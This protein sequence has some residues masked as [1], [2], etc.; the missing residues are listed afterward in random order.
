MGN[1]FRERESC[2]FPQTTTSDTGETRE[3]HTI[4]RRAILKGALGIGAV[5]VA[6]AANGKTLDLQQWLDTTDP[7][8]VADYHARRLAEAMGQLD[9]TR[10]YRLHVNADKGF[11]LIV[12]DPIE[13]RKAP[14]ARVFLDDGEP[15]LAAD[16]AQTEDYPPHKAQPH[17]EHDRS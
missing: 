16:R 14:V 4:A 7:F 2:A 6:D 8:W 12:G 1:H 10:V 5:S 13:D 11:A 3:P 15:L 9:A 17:A